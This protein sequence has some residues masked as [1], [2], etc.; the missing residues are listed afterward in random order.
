V[1]V[2]SSTFPIL[3][4]GFVAL[5]F[6]GCGRSESTGSPGAPTPVPPVS[7]PETVSVRILSG[8]THQSVAGAHVVI[9]GQGYSTDQNGLVPPLP[10][11]SLGADV[12]VQEVGYLPRATRL[13]AN[14]Y[15]QTVTLW[16]IANDAEADAI[17]RMVFGRMGQPDLLY[18][19]NPGEFFLTM[20]SADPAVSAAWR[21]GA[22]EF[23]AAFGFAYVLGTQ[24]MYDQNEISVFF[25]LDH[26]CTPASLSGFCRASRSYMDFAVATDRATDRITIR[27]VLA[28]QFLG[29]NP[30]P[31][32]LNPDAPDDTLSPFEV[33]TIRMILQHPRKTYWPDNDRP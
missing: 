20:P 17:H 24:F 1:I 10:K 6:L 30:L 8:S 5:T 18:P 2:R 9:D 11:T 13:G 23:G 14:N 31:G 29:P 12:D 22:A 32:L 4:A 3:V 25:G 28:S 7:S 27:R 19:P 15:D 21:A 33:Q 16:P 26:G